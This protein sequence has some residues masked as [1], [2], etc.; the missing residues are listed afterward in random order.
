MKKIKIG[1]SGATGRMGQGIVQAL[2]HH[3]NL[4]LSAAYA[5]A[6]NPLKGQVIDA[7]VILSD[8][9]DDLFKN[10]DVIIDFSQPQ[11]TAVLLEHAQ[12]FKKPLVIGTTGLDQAHLNLIQKA[13]KQMPIVYARNTSIGITVMQEI[14]K[15]LTLALGEDFDIEL[16]ETHH[17]HKVDAPSGTCLMLA[18]AAAEARGVDLQKVARFERHGH[19]GV[20]PKREI[21]FSVRRGGQSPGEHTISFLSD[22]ESIEITH[23]SFSRSLFVKGAL[24]AAE[25]VVSQSAGLY[26]MADVLK[27]K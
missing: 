1:L 15:Q 14:V 8:Q 4:E 3:Q 6:T 19:V 21:G 27:D 26:G 25:W 13:S 9:I 22:E 23:H 16:S 18:E 17:R 2:K 20:R 10:S 11:A 7:T 24:K 12:N 5:S